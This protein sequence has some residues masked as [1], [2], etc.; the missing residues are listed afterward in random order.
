L[1][2]A[3]PNGSIYSVI[4][5][6][7]AGKTTV[8][9][10]VTGVYLP[11]EGQIEFAGREIRRP[12]RARIALLCIAIGLFTSIVALLASADVN[13]LWRAVIKRNRPVAET[14]SNVEKK[15]ETPAA[16]SFSVADAAHDFWGYL[17]G[18]IAVE[19][20]NVE[21]SWIVVPWNAS[22]PAFGTAE[23]KSAA[24]DLAALVDSVV[25]GERP[26]E[27]LPHS[28]NGWKLDPS[29]ATETAISEIRR[30]RSTQ[31]LWEWLA[32][33]SAF[34]VASVG[35]Y[36]V[37]NRARRTP[38]VI[39]L[40][41]IARTF[42]NIR[43]FTSMTVLENVQA[44]IDRSM[45]HRVRNIVIVAGVA[46]VLGAS[47]VGAMESQAFWKPAFVPAA[48]VGLSIVVVAL[49]AWAQ[50]QKQRDESESCREAFDGLGFVALQSKAGALAGSLAYG[51]Q[52]RLEIARALALKPRL[53]LLDEPA[54]GM[55][56]TESA[57]LMR[58]IRRIRES[59]VTVLLIEHHMKVVMGI[60][61][62]LAVLDH[63]VKIAEGTPAEIR[64][65]PKVIEAYLGKEST[66]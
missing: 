18:H 44:G 24:R 53:L 33:V 48:M 41:G 55:N 3:V 49:L 17:A 32:L 51:D 11:T 8:F 23:S 63:G 12:F 16:D 27:S 45:R 31:I 15:A 36:V 65:N 30:A 50:W 42:Q 62:R 46:L 5:P 25:A 6:N 59:G 29:R 58:L 28:G 47:L 43:L 22:R 19:Y 9:N 57:D 60:S 26:L 1:D 54:A 21:K 13:G 35:T 2:L 61:D 34:V 38:D 7:G 10:A 40:S 20:R 66:D 4:G 37:W 56:P 52:R 14:S 39:A 64:A